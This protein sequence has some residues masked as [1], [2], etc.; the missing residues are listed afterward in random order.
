MSEDSH[1][2]LLGVCIP[3][4]KRPEWLCKCVDS[5]VA[6]AG[7]F[8]VPIFIADDSEDLTNDETVAKLKRQY[9]W[10]YCEKNARNLGID[11]NILKAVALCDCKYAWLL[12]EDDRMCPTAISEVLTALESN[13]VPPAFVCVNYAAVDDSGEQC[14]RERVVEIA[15][16]TV[17]SGRVF[18]EEFAWACGFIGS[19][20]VNTELWRRV[21]S[22]KYVGTYFA[23]LGVI[24]EYAAERSIL[25]LA[26]PKVLNRCG[27]LSVVTWSSATFDVMEGFATL[28]ERLEAVYGKET[29]LRGARS[30]SRAH[31]F[32]SIRFLLYARAGGAYGAAECQRVIARVG[33]TRAFKVIARGVTLVPPKLLRCFQTLKRRMMMLSGAIR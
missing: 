20:V 18:V 33:G 4:Y 11:R 3:T 17:I 19:C 9:K 10:V 22:E 7:P 16:D 1:N 8:R 6:A 32:D 21:D 15:S 12:G 13:S 26:A 29:C 2:R 28:M 24:C 5:I 27:S 14:L 23:H 25:V 30:F 31:H